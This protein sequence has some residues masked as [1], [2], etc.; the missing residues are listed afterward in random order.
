MTTLR[1]RKPT[2]AVPAPL[3]L[4]EGIEGSGKTYA[5]VALSTHPKIRNTYLLDLGEGSMDEYASIASPN[6]VII[7]HNGTYQDIAGQVDAVHKLPAPTDGTFDLFVI[8]SA[9]LLWGQQVDAV[10]AE[11]RRR[12]KTDATMDQWNTAKRNWRYI[13]DRL[14]TWH[15]IVVLTARGKEV[16]DVEGGRPV[17][18]NR[19]T[20][21]VWK[22]E[23]EKSIGYDVNAWIRFTGHQTAELVKARSLRVQ[24]PAGETLPLPN[25]NLATFVFDTL[26]IGTVNT[27]TRQITELSAESMTITEA[28]FHLAARV[29]EVYGA[30]ANMK[31]LGPEWW[32][33]SGI[34]GE[35]D[36]VVAGEAVRGFLKTV[37][38]PQVETA[39]AETPAAT[40]EYDLPAAGATE[41]DT[42]E[43]AA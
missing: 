2:G 16:V 13:L 4:L 42:T 41:D 25:F 22:V 15:G 8:D 3:I 39:A 38:L 17:V 26:G 36:D 34:V 21:K 29:R 19:V 32:G 6:A 37:K 1:T 23:A 10:S 28:K 14:M 30:D 33:K 31:E 40:S 7:D 35:A 24:I 9:T 43:K 27:G 18:I 5:G 12:N 20:Q 11:T